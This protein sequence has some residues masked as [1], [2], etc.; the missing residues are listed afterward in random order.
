MS[1]RPE[2]SDELEFCGDVTDYWSYTQVRDWV[3]LHPQLN[4]TALHLYL[5]LRSMLTERRPGG[6]RRMSVDQLC[7]LLPGVK[8]K[9]AS[10]TMVEDALRL[11]SKIDLVVNPD[12]GRLVTS[13]GDRG[14][15]TSLRKYKVNDLPLD[16]YTGW[17][18]VWDKLDAYR[19]GWREDPPQPP[20]HVRTE[21]GMIR[22]SGVR[23]D[24]QRNQETT[25]RLEP[26][27]TGVTTRKTG[28][29]TRK[30]TARK[31]LTSEIASPQKAS[32]RRSPLSPPT[33]RTAVPESSA[34]AVT[35]EDERPTS[36]GTSEAECVSPVSV[37]RQRGE[38]PAFGQ[39]DVRPVVE[40]FAQ[41]HRETFGSYP[42]ADLVD[43]VSTD[44]VALTASHWPVTHVARL[45][46]ELPGKG[47]R[48]LARHAEFNPPPK[49]SSTGPAKCAACDE[50]RMRYRDPAEET[51]A[52]RCPCAFPHL[53]TA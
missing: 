49:P 24:Q 31:P 53:G 43:A 36:R 50:N 38:P 32:R 33:A 6:L 30:K 29:T 16:R 5:L 34:D 23:G 48:S 37:P 25:G 42:A 13:T 46:G 19:E 8:G 11:L 52:Y 39:D 35:G 10:K 12:G 7:W 15:K 26:R 28:V 41:A 21:E 51:G 44:A 20:S 40:A 2:D 1:T 3:L 17:K 4:R 9:P 27:K 18:N 47:F 45:A 14:V 22:F